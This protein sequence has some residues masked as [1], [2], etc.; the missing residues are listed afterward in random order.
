MKSRID[1]RTD[2]AA[3]TAVA[4]MTRGSGRATEATFVMSRECGIWSGM[5]TS[6]ASS[7]SQCLDRI[8]GRAYTDR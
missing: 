5:A 6:S 7:V 8:A 2:I 1:R 3:S 4:L